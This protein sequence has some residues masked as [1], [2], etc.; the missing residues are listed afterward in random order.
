METPS[1][2]KKSGC[3]NRRLGSMLSQRKDK[4]H[5]VRGGEKTSHQCTGTKGIKI[6]SSSLYSEGKI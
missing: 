1:V 3:I 4:V 2:H 6:C 5:F